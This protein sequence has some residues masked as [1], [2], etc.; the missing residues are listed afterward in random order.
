MNSNISC[1]CVFGL[2]IMLMC[3][4]VHMEYKWDQRINLE[5]LSPGPGD[6]PWGWAGWPAGLRGLPVSVSQ[7]WD[8]KCVT[9]LGFLCGLWR[10]NCGPCLHNKHFPYWAVP[11]RLRYFCWVFFFFG[12]CLFETRF[13]YIAS[14][15]L[16][17]CV[18]QDGVHYVPVLF[19]LW[20]DSS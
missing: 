3:V 4:Q 9:M 14:A 2:Y 10:L 11:Q 6:H 5:C 18:N 20:R 17:L 16:E 7:C 12:C 13:L 15:V 1:V 8:Y 19:G